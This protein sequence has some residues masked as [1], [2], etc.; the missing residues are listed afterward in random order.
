MHVF[1]Q[2]FSIMLSQKYLG[3]AIMISQA[4][5]SLSV[6]TLSQI[7]FHSVSQCFARFRRRNLYFRIVSQIDFRKVSRVRKS[8]FFARFRNAVC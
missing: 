2:A 4:F 8:C 7:W 5:A 1:S 6:G 3:F